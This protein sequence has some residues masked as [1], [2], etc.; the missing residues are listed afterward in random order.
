[1]GQEFLL[2]LQQL[3]KRLQIWHCLQNEAFVLEV[4]RKLSWP[5][6]PGELTAGGA[7]SEKLYFLCSQASTSIQTSLQHSSFISGV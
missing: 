6:L 1:L 2:Q 7:P 3:Q 5:Q 4:Q